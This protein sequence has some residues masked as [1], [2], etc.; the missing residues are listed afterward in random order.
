MGLAVFSGLF[1]ATILAIFTIPSL[2]V[3]V[4]KYFVRD[5]KTKEPSPNIASHEHGSEEKGGH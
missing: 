1:I 3:M 5:K 4:E 2:F